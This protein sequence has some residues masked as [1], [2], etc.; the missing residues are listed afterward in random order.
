MNSGELNSIVQPAQTVRSARPP[1]ASSATGARARAPPA[2]S[3]R[4]TMGRRAGARGQQPVRPRRSHRHAD[5]SRRRA[6][7]RAGAA[8]TPAMAALP[9]AAASM[10]TMPKPS[11][12]PPI[13][14]FTRTKTSHTRCTSAEDP[15]SARGQ[16]DGRGPRPP[17]PRHAIEVIGVLADADD[18]QMH[19]EAVRAQRRR[20]ADQV[21]KPLRRLS[22]R[23]TG[24]ASTPPQAR[25]ARRSSARRPGESVRCR[26]RDE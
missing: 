1:P 9:Q 12:S 22:G 14:R 6:R 5:R 8:G 7:R 2:P 4:A 10:N 24:P 18:R 16:A 20:T 3:T 13:S 21:S 15:P 23:P 19:I 26:H 25:P 17:P 11:V